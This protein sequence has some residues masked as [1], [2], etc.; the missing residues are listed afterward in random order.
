MGEWRGPDRF[1]LWPPLPV[2]R[3]LWAPDKALFLSLGPGGVESVHELQLAL[4]VSYR[5]AIVC[6]G[7]KYVDLAQAADQLAGQ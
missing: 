2:G 5:T 6:A 1:A 7:G 4:P 3:P